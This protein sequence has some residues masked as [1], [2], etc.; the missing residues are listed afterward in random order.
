MTTSTDKK[1]ET[2]IPFQRGKIKNKVLKLEATV[3][4]L[5]AQQAQ[6]KD[7]ATKLAAEQKKL[8]KNIATDVASAGL[9]STALE[10]DATTAQRKCLQILD[11]RIL[12]LWVYL[13][14]SKWA[15]TSY[16]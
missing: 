1:D 6:G 13:Y 5:Q 7:V 14:N 15:K 9:A 16:K 8:D 2:N 10:F 4:K 11:F 12:G 3:L